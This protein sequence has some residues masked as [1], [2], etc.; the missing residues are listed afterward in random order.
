MSF[1]TACEKMEITPPFTREEL[2]KQYYHLALK[3]HPD[4]NPGK[5][6]EIGVESFQDMR[7]SYIY[8]CDH[9]DHNQDKFFNLNSNLS[10]SMYNVILNK[11]IMSITAAI[12]NMNYE[13]FMKLYDIMKKN[14]IESRLPQELRQLIETR[15]ET[16]KKHNDLLDTVILE[17]S[18]RDLFEHNIFKYLYVEN[19][20][21]YY[22]PMWH[23][24]VYFNISK[25]RKLKIICKPKLP[26]TFYIDNDNNLHINVY[27]KIQDL[28]D[29][30][31]LKIHLYDTSYIYLATDTLLVRKYQIQILN[32]KGYSFINTHDIYNIDRKANIIIHLQLS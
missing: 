20:T 4:K 24:E 12:D 31:Q 30:K 3:Y 32:K 9:T 23:S 15:H 19:S 2:K 6:P 7:E 26:D 29:L 5:N 14:G 25:N 13:I 8:L 10:G 16:I 17:P 22:V 28:L 21:E 18:V 1:K 27:K 11:F